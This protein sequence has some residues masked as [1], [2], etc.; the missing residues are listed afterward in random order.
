TLGEKQLTTPLK[1]WEEMGVPSFTGPAV[2]KQEFTLAA[3]SPQGKRVYLDL[4]NVHEDAR[5]QL[6]G[7]PLDARPW[8]PYVWDVTQLIKSGANTLEVQVRM[9]PA[10][11]QRG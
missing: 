5:V 4:G 7:A 2:Y 8:P 1:S 10:G 11:E 3:A 6:N 9:A